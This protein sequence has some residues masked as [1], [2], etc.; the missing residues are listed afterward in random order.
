MVYFSG[1][2]MGEYRPLERDGEGEVSINGLQNH[3]LTTSDEIRI[4]KP[5]GPLPHHLEPM[6]PLRKVSFIISILLCGLTIV[7]FLW[8]LPCDWAT[9]PSTSVRF[10]TKSWERTLQGLGELMCHDV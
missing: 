5:D 1:K 2:K 4:I 7:I 10:R 3:D 8:I 9:C 6:S